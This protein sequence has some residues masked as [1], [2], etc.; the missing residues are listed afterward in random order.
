[1][2]H[3]GGGT[4]LDA[5]VGGDREPRQ[6]S[7]L[8]PRRLAGQVGA[9]IAAAST[10]VGLV[11]GARTAWDEFHRPPGELQVSLSPPLVVAA[12]FARVKNESDVRS[13]G[14]TPL[15][16]NGDGRLGALIKFN[17]VV[18]KGSE[19]ARLPLSVRL[20]GPGTLRECLPMDARIIVQPGDAQGVFKFWAML[21]PGTGPYAVDVRVFRDE[22]RVG[23]LCE[24]ESGSFMMTVP[25]QPE[26]AQNVPC[27][28]D[29]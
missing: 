15:G 27:R 13:C 1:M 22:R 9:V 21:R 24:K 14:P 19:R 3:T 12:P 7:R 20:S 18:S 10:V 4:A 17:A 29:G 2:G 8:W 25:I 16:G 23:V 26:G 28:T 11:V 5:N 6:R